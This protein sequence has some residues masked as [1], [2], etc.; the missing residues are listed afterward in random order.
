MKI[1]KINKVVKFIVTLFLVGLIIGILGYMLFK[2]KIEPYLSDFT[3]IVSTN[4]I[5]TFLLNI[6]LISAIFILSISI[7]GLPLILLYLF[8][9]GFSI[10]YTLMAFASIYGF[11]GLLFYILY[12]III[13]LIFIIC[14]LYFTYM[15]TKF[16]I[17]LVYYLSKRKKEEVYRIFT[18][19]L[20]RYLL[21]L[22][23][24]I[25]NCTLIYFLASKIISIFLPLIK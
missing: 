22:I 9:E 1:L 25:L 10:G 6:G 12:F 16:D 2:P 18:N 13:K 14:I 11:K 21:V 4:H 17:K 24:V 23:T 15:S 19:Q 8:Y 20:Y 7:I 3:N 5:N